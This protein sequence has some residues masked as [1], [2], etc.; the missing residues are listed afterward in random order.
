VD[1]NRRGVNAKL[2]ICQKILNLE[3]FD[4]VRLKQSRRNVSLVRV[5]T[6]MQG[7]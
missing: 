3:V 6:M 1:E 5:E 4:Q 2:E 7:F